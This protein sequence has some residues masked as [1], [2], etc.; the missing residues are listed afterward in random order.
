MGRS[1]ITISTLTRVGRMATVPKGFVISSTVFNEFRSQNVN[2]SDRLLPWSVELEIAKAYDDLGSNVVNVLPS[3]SYPSEISGSYI[4]DKTSLVTEIRKTMTDFLSEEE[5]DCRKGQEVEV[6]QLAFLVQEIPPHS[7]SGSIE[8]GPV[9]GQYEVRAVLGLPVDLTESDRMT[10]GDDGSVA[11]KTILS[12]ERMWIAE[13]G[14]KKVD[15]ERDQ[16]REMK[17]PSDLLRKLSALGKRMTTKVGTGTFHW[18]LKDR[19][20]IVWSV[21][22]RERTRRPAPEPMAEVVTVKREIPSR[23]TSIF[24]VSE[25]LPEDVKRAE[26]QGLFLVPSEG[27]R[28]VADELIRLSERLAPRP[29]VVLAG[30]KGMGSLAGARR[31]GRKNLWPMFT[32]TTSEFREITRPAV[33]KGLERSKDL[34]FW[35]TANSP[36]TLLFLKDVAEEFDGI[37]IPLDEVIRTMEGPGDK[38]FDLTVSALGR[39]VEEARERGLVTAIGI[40]TKD[41]LGD[42]WSYCADMGVDILAVDDKLMDDALSLWRAKEE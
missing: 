37:F 5:E 19:I 40:S 30:E 9:D 38:R 25:S 4:S 27:S 35:A 16:R 2:L 15:V 21:A 10:I 26:I 1:G 32:T 41:R 36:T 22:L 11:E 8:T 34:P 7:A 31:D 24:L 28:P 29:I 23:E 6:F 3:P 39:I 20:F 18:Y 14:L 33:E 42:I 12:Q 17:V 13:D